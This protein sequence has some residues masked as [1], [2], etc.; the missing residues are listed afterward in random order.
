ML[1]I[2]TLI[3]L[4]LLGLMTASCDGLKNRLKN[5][6]DTSARAKYERQFSG[7][8]SLMTQ[9]KQKYAAATACNL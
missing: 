4:L 2:K 8:D 6:L 9:W 1:R 3:I 5:M 7:A